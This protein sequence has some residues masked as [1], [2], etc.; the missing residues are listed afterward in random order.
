MFS[1]K[2][3]IYNKALNPTNCF[4]KFKGTDKSFLILSTACANNSAIAMLGFNPDLV[5]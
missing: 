5:T 3:V 2:P 1:S 4:C